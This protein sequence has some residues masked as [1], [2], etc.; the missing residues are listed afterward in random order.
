MK[1]IQSEEKNESTKYAYDI[2]IKDMYDLAVKIFP[3][4]IKDAHLLVLK[5]INEKENKEFTLEMIEKHSTFKLSA[6][7]S[8]FYLLKYEKNQLKYYN[9]FL[10]LSNFL[11]SKIHL[12]DGQ[13]DEISSKDFRSFII[14]GYCVLECFRYLFME[15]TDINSYHRQFN[16]NNY[17]NYQ[18][19][20]ESINLEPFTKVIYNKFQKEFYEKNKPNNKGEHGIYELYYQ[21]LKAV[22]NNNFEKDYENKIMQNELTK[23]KK[24]EKKL[25]KRQNKKQLNEEDKINDI[26]IIEKTDED[27]NKEEKEK[28]SSGKNNVEIQDDEKKLIDNNQPNSNTGNTKSND[29]NLKCLSEQ[30][31][32]Q[33]NKSET[34]LSCKKAKNEEKSFNENEKKGN[35]KQEVHQNE[36]KGNDNQEVNQNEEQSKNND[37]E[38][39]GKEN[40][41]K[42]EIEKDN[43]DNLEILDK[44]NHI[45][46]ESQEEYKGNKENREKE[47][48]K[49]IENQKVNE[50]MDMVKEIMKENQ[51][52]KAKCQ[53]MD[54]ENQKKFQK[55]NEEYQT[56][57]QKLNE[58]Y[59][60]TKKKLNEEKIK[61]QE[62]INEL[63]NNIEHLSFLVSLFINRDTIK[64]CISC[65]INQIKINFKNNIKEK[66]GAKLWMK[67]LGVINEIKD[68]NERKKYKKLVNVLFFLKDY[69]NNIVHMK[70]IKET[71]LMEGGK[72]NFFFAFPSYEGMKNTLNKLLTDYYKEFVLFNHMAYNKSK[73]FKDEEFDYKEYFYEKD[74][75]ILLNISNITKDLNGFFSWVSEQKM[76]KEI[77]AEISD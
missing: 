24:R 76:E 22:K 8:L 60:E 38:M 51:E 57:F 33:T 59:Q 58:E 75:K 27:L 70:E 48:Q 66:D 65:V 28:N 44:E 26:N 34:D 16:L 37:K 18:K 7:D 25:A 69:I 46:K 72:K 5:T 55:L 23:K 41:K 14:Y 10:F 53:K 36:K 63:Q 45:M 77:E 2:I 9:L 17:K 50:L 54:E 61:F 64:C 30:T 11:K 13:F 4:K 12:L 73:E 1:S 56:K 39:E 20:L 21:F 62:K 52:I 40:E 19:Y 71:D 31:C 32:K 42:K 43:K 67:A 3:N 47:K 68:D 35:D 15:K 29:S 74:N 49:N 6:L